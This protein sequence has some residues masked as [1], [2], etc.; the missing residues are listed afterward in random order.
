MILL[1]AG[2]FV[3]MNI[4]SG[5]YVWLQGRKKEIVL[6][7]MAGAARGQI[8]GWLLRDFFL[9]F[10][11][12]FAVAVILVWGI[13]WGSSHYNVSPA[14]SLLIGN[15]LEWQGVALSFGAVG[16]LCTVMVSG[17]MRHYFK[18]QIIQLVH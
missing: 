7:K 2:I 4:F 13:I 10:T 11:G 5:I 14:L 18:K 3:L 1:L 15:D 8:Y 17:F 16:L 9:F 6:R 12:S